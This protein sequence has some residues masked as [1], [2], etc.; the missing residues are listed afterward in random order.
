MRFKP[1]RISEEGKEYMNV[2]LKNTVIKGVTIESIAAEGKCV[3]RFENQV[4]FVDKVAP[5]DVVDIKIIKKKKNFLIGIPVNFVEYSKLRTE[6][7]CEHF[8]SCGGCKW[9]HIDYETQLYYKRQQVID[10]LERIARVPLPEVKPILPAADTRH[11]RNKL[12]FTFSNKRWITTEEIK[13]GRPIDKN[14]LGFHIPGRYD[15]IININRCHL[16]GDISNRIRLETLQ[17]AKE[18]KMEF[19]DLVKHHGMLRNLIIRL[20]N[21]KEVMVIVQFGH[22]DHDNICSLLGHLKT[23]FPEITSLQYMINEKGNETYQDLE[24][25]PYAGKPYITEDMGGLK[26]RIG[27]KSFFQTNSSQ[28]LKL[29]EVA[30]QFA[31]LSGGEIVYDLYTG[32]GTIANFVAHQATKVIGLEYVEEAIENAKINSSINGIN[33][34]EF[35]AG[36]IKGILNEAFV[37]SHPAPDVIITDPP[38]AGMHQDVVEMLLNIGAPKIVYISCNPATQ[39]RDIA[40][41]SSGYNVLEVQPVDMFPQT[42]HVECVVLLELRK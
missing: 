24:I 6:P 8:G 34:T 27:P 16:Q 22:N 1:K 32:T 23:R 38:R 29:Y 18:K 14:G 12:E 7:F 4:I 21:Q 17:Y 19:Y 11:Y 2:R 30:R 5:G 3:A 40:L 36:D 13:S 26:F 15:K 20:S 42:Y 31:G 35:Y 10:N 41:L 28:A 37:A 33:N 25:I 9:Q 39:A